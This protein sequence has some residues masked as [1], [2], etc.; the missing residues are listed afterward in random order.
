MEDGRIRDGSL[1]IGRQGIYRFYSAVSAAA[2]I[3]VH[4]LQPG[5]VHPGLVGNGFVQRDGYGQLF[6][7]I[8]LL[9]RLSGESVRVEIGIELLFGVQADGGQF[10]YVLTIGNL[11]FQDKGLDAFEHTG[12]E[13]YVCLHYHLIAHARERS[14]LRLGCQG[15][16]VKNTKDKKQNSFHKGIDYKNIY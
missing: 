10:D 3:Q 12:S 8:D 1:G 5:A 7:G 13:L 9:S 11:G 16:G 2:F 15:N 4:Q 6:F 14:V